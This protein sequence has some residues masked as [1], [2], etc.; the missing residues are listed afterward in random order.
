MKIQNIVKII[1]A[2][3]GVLAAFFLLRIIGTGDDDIKMAATMGDFG[4]VSPLVELA[5]IVLVLTVAITLIF[6][7]RGLFSDLAKLKKAGIA[8]GLFLAVV[9][10]SYALSDGVE[11]P[12]KDGEMLSASG[13]KWVGTGIRT[14]YILAVLAIG[15]MLVSGARKIFNK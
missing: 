2:V 8:I 7:L 3:I 11:T 4:A 13:S 1:S 10:L 9:F 14:F 5:R 15:L 12:L 6:T